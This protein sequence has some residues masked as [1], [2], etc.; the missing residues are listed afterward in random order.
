[1]DDVSQVV[2]VGAG[3]AGAPTPV[4]LRSEGSDG[5]ATLV[6]AEPHLPYERPPLSKTYPRGETARADAQPQGRESWAGQGTDLR[7]GTPVEAIDAAARSVVLADGSALDGDRLVLATGS[8]GRSAAV[9]G[10]DLFTST[11][12]RLGCRCLTAS[13]LGSGAPT[14]SIDRRRAF[15]RPCDSA[16]VPA[17]GPYGTSDPACTASREEKAA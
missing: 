7:T 17:A 6:G 10:P 13:T 12:S 8:A 3:Q 14:A 9:P 4:A 16:E 1:M 5:S 2:I 15:G 11:R